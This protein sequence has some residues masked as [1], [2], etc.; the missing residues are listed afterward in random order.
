[1]KQHRRIL[2]LALALAITMCLLPTSTLAA[3]AEESARCKYDVIDEFSDGMARVGVQVGTEQEEYD[4]EVYESLV[5]QYGFID[6]T[7]AEVIAPQYSRAE[8]FS[9]GLALVYEG[10]RAHFI[11]KTGARVS[12]KMEYPCYVFGTGFHNGLFA[13]YRERDDLEEPGYYC[14]YVDKAGKEVIPC[15]YDDIEDFSEGLARV[16]IGEGSAC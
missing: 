7:G 6:Q 4:G 12:I 14:G 8:N 9:D 15:I 3:D 2:S 16:G 13:V 1:M 11:D 5:Y 10:N